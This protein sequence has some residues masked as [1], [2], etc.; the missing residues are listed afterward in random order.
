MWREG[1][2]GDIINED[3]PEGWQEANEASKAIEDEHK[4]DKP[5]FSTAEGGSVFMDYKII[6]EQVDADL[7]AIARLF[8]AEMTR[9]E[10]FDT[11]TAEVEG[12]ISRTKESI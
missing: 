10:I 5:H 1:I 9:Q 8:R 6:R 3:L 2:L 11:A 7:R 4:T 12:W